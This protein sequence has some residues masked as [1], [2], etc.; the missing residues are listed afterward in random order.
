MAQVGCR[1]AIATENTLGR[2]ASGCDHQSYARQDNHAAD[3]RRNLLL[4]ACF[5]PKRYFA[6]LYSVLLSV[7]NRN[8]QQHYSGNH[9]HQPQPEQSLHRIVS[10]VLT[11]RPSEK[12]NR[13]TPTGRDSELVS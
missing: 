10:S 8:K 6:C 4:S 7:G 11:M 3:R 13:H 2:S 5:N 1:K 9:C 12:S